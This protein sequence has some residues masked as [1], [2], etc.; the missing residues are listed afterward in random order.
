LTGAGYTG[1][2]R[3]RRTSR[4]VRVAERVA[5]ALISIGGIG[6]ILA[7]ALI[8]VFLVSVVQP[9]FRASTAEARAVVV[10][11]RGEADEVAAS[12][13]PRSRNFVRVGLDEYQRMA[14]SLDASG[15]IEYVSLADG[16]ILGSTQL[17]LDGQ[18]PCVV[19]A[20]SPDGEFALAYPDGRL[21]LGRA[22]FRTTYFDIEN[23]PPEL[24]ELAVGGSMPYASGIAQRPSFEQLRV[25]Q[26]ESVLLEPLSTPAGARIV[27]LD[28][29][30]ATQ[31]L[32]IAWLSEAGVLSLGKIEEHENPMT[33]DVSLELVTH[34]APAPTGDGLPHEL[35]LTGFGDSLIALWED[36]RALRYDLRDLQRIEIAE[37]LDLVAAGGATVTSTELLIGRST[38]AVGASDGSLKCWFRVRP[39]LPTTSDGGTL[40]AGHVLCE[41]GPAISSL[42]ASERSRLLA[43]GSADGTARLYYVPTEEERIAI[44]PFESRDGGAPEAAAALAL[45][46]KEDGWVVY[47]EQRVASLALDIG[48]PDGSLRALFRPLWYE[49]YDEPEHVW[50]SSSGTDEFEPKLGLVPLV[51]GTL[52]ATLFSLLFGVPLA[53]MAA[54][55]TSEFLTPSLRTPIKSC[56]EMMASLPSVVLGFLAAL[57]IAPFAQRWLP[58][59]LALFLTVPFCLL[60]GAYLWQFLPGKVAVRMSGKTRLCAVFACLP[61]AIACALVVGPW[62]EA[63]C[64][65]GDVEAWLDRSG[66]GAFPGWFWLLLPVGAGLAILGLGR[67]AGPWL[68]RA[69]VSWTRRQCAVADLVRFAVGALLA[70]G[71]AAALSSALCVGGFDARGSLVDTYVQRN[72]LIVGFVMGFAIIPIIYTLAEDALSS[73]PHS[74]RLASLGAGATPWQT[75]MRIVVPTAGSG[76]F[77]AIMV[78]L[79]RAVGET[80]IVLMATGNTPVMEWNVFSGFRTLS[81]NIAVELPEAARDSTHYRTLFLAALTLFAITFLVNTLAEVVRQRF[82]KRSYQ[83]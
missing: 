45:A 61:V 82:R 43:A 29:V 50:Q 64:F 31:G 16:S 1:R 33:G 48:H 66:E 80:M 42:A 40:A 9:L 13:A 27:A 51:F 38:L 77:S 65:G 72:A 21:R 17:A 12:Q 14:W 5:R 4:S 54:V 22:A 75:A 49:G 23:A 83:L 20:S 26:P 74:L 10:V 59:M 55:F 76:L 71:I 44:Q 30:R 25:Q 32:R 15:R 53:L 3:A 70:A 11:A 28:F 19:C 36:G 8:L 68:R 24:R 34:A 6:T 2:R 79:G 37:E 39:A 41:S 78:G 63:W 60:L 52:K 67:F 7:V 47:G 81:A 35:V 57:V 56:I 73:V 69:S 62:I 46:P 58:A 18:A